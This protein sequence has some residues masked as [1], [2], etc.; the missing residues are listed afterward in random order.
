MKKKRI[1]SALLVFA[2]GM[3]ISSARL[4]DVAPIAPDGTDVGFSTLNKAVFDAIGVHWGWYHLT[5]A[6]GYLALG[7]AGAFALFG[8][9]QLIRRKSFKKVD[10]NLL[11]LG[12]LYLTVIA[13]Y[14]IFELFPVNYR[15]ILMPGKTEPEPSFPSSHTLLICT[16]MLSAAHQ[17]K[18]YVRKT[19]L[20][21]T[22]QGVC[23]GLAV[24]TV[25]GRLLSG[26][27]W[28]TDI[29]GGLL[30]SAALLYPFVTETE[31]D[32]G[33]AA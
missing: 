21:R 31:A 9:W 14:V 11:W 33:K 2:A 8:L 17:L 24:L 25:C 4:I 22:L 19:S 20:R 1:V 26:V 30:L 16:V 12:G 23:C 6:L 28:F 13:L 18:Y 5:D 27:H 3:I 29:L 10:R 7:V 32:R 15:P